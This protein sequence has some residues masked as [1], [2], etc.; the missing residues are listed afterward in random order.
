MK[1]TPQA[2]TL[3]GAQLLEGYAMVKRITDN[4]TVYHEPPYTWKEERDFYRRI[5]GGPITVL[6]GPPAKP[7]SEP[8]QQQ[9][10]GK[11]PSQD[12]Q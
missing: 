9:Q 5:G 6:R 8:P 10:Q 3:L 11:D 12:Q 1:G 4:G 2:S 7:S